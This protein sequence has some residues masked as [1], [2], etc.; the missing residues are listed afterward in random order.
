[1]IKNENDK[2]INRF[3]EPNNKFY[4]QAL[5]EVKNGKKKTHWIWFIFPQIKGL[6]ISKMS[7]FYGIND[8]DEAKA[9]LNHEILGKRLIEITKVLFGVKI[10]NPITIFVNDSNKIKSCMTLF[11]LASSDKTNN[12]FKNVLD[13]YYNGILDNKTIEILKKI[14]G[15]K[16]F[17]QKEKDLNNKNI[18]EKNNKNIMKEKINDK[19]IKKEVN[20]KNNIQNKD[21]I[22]IKNEKEVKDNNI[23]KNEVN[24]NNNIQKKENNISINKAQVEENK[25]INKDKL[26]DN[27][28]INNDKDNK[29]I[30]KKEKTI[31]TI[32]KEKDNKNLIKEKDGKKT[33]KKEKNYENKNNQNN[34]QNKLKENI[35]IKEINKISKPNISQPKINYINKF[36]IKKNNK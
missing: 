35:Q 20:I 16:N 13:K 30:E 17:E 12:V 6:G 29:I 22:N 4:Q 31:K 14:D 33:E 19:N 2:S 27:K 21:K 26:Q 24:E 11:Y 25:N 23:I 34:S 28:N 9:Y 3:V 1:M 5:N 7:K 32:Q 8:L 15:T 18:E 10:N 36:P